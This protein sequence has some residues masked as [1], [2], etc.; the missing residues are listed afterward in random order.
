MLAPDGAATDGANRLR[1]FYGED[2]GELAKDHR[3]CAR[4][5]RLSVPA[6]GAQDFC[7]FCASLEL[8]TRKR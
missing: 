7:A 1:Y 5:N 8:D 2:I 4:D 6:P 3:A